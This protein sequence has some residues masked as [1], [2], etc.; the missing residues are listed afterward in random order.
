MAQST[1]HLN[2]LPRRDLSFG[3]RKGYPQEHIELQLAHMKRDKVD[4][5]Y[6]Y[7]KYL[8]ARTKMMQDWADFLDQQQRG[9]K[10]LKGAK[11]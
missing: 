1:A 9:A 3:V 7:A 6:N 11:G 4:A 2:S 8:P 5:A 10:A